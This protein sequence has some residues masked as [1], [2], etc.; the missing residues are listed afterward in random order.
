MHSEDIGQ[1]GG[2]SFYILETIPFGFDIGDLVLSNLA[3]I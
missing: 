1:I 3:G 2:F